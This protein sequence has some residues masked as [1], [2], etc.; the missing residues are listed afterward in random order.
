M[1]RV[2]SPLIL[3]AVLPQV[4]HGKTPGYPG[5]IKREVPEAEMDE[6]VYHIPFCNSP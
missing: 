5:E 6:N 4:I 2:Q 1:A 3:V